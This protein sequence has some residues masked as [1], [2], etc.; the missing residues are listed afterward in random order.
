VRGL[1]LV[2][3]GLNLTLILVR[4]VVNDLV[5]LGESVVVGNSGTVVS[6]TAE[7]GLGTLL[8]LDLNSDDLDLVVGETDLDLELVGHHKLIGFNGVVV[9][10]L[11]LLLLVLLL[12]LH[13]QVF[14]N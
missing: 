11:L 4:V 12:L 10:L 8:L 14:S 9:V 13:L 5:G 6:E 2:L 1:G 3:V 7:V